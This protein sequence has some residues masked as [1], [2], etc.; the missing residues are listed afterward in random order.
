[1][2]EIIK[3]TFLLRRGYTEVWERNNPILQLGE[4]GFEIDKNK[5]KVGDGT[6]AWKNLPYIGGTATLLADGAIVIDNETIKLFGFEAA[7]IGAQPRKGKNG[8]LEWYVP[9]SDSVEGLQSAFA[10][11][12]QEFTDLQEQFSKLSD[13]NENIQEQV[14][15]I[16]LSTENIEGGEIM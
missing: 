12:Q 7:E 1:M 8:E 11:L 10:T 6:T 14:D 3:T 9:T 16:A 2:A 4:P 13:D 15:K 5:L